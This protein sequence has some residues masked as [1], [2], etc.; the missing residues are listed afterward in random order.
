[1][2]VAAPNTRDSTMSGEN[3]FG[4][5]LKNLR[6]QRKLTQ[7]DVSAAVGVSRPYLAGM[8]TD[9]DLPGREVLMALATF[10]DVNVDWLARGIGDQRGAVAVTEQEQ[11]LLFAFRNLP[12]EQA[13]MFLRLMLS[14]THQDS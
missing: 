8:E 7:V 10:Y 6:V 12:T 14:R 2:I 11:L 3:T 1:M 13:E 5:R 9:K 4:T